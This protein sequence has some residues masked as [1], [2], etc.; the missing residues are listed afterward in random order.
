[1]LNSEGEGSTALVRSSE[2]CDAQKLK[3]CSLRAVRNSLERPASGVPADHTKEPRLTF[4]D[5]VLQ[6]LSHLVALLQVGG[7]GEAVPGLCELPLQ[8]L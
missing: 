2:V 3:N 5:G 6:S 8:P 1:M 4:E 7:V